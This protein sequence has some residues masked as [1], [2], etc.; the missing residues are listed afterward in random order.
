MKKFFIILLSI[1]II[2][3]T[4]YIYNDYKSSTKQKQYFENI[5][6]V[7]DE[8]ITSNNNDKDN[9]NNNSNT[10]TEENVAQ[11]NTKKQQY[12]NIS[13]LN[14][15]GKLKIEKINI[16]YPIIEYVNEDSLLTSIC[17]ISDNNIDGTGNL[18]L[19]GH[20]M[21]NLSMFGNLKQTNIGD[22]VEITN[23]KGKKYTYIVTEKKYVDSSETE[24]LD[25]TSSPTLTLVTCKSV[26]RSQRLIIIATLN[27]IEDI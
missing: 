14:V 26:N 15:Y 8:E 16:E 27:K 20:N 2:A 9:N 23:A 17:K 21:R 5:I 13:G 10:L 24:V 6:N 1:S 7:F 18:C 3:L 11:E 22:T 4:L 12:I 19:A 25:D